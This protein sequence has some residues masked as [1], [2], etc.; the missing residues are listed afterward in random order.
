MTDQEI[1]IAIAEAMGA[2]E[3]LESP[4]FGATAY[5][6]ESMRQ[7]LEGLGLHV[8]NSDE[9]DGKVVCA[10][11]KFCNDLNAMHAAEETLSYLDLKAYRQQLMHW[12]CTPENFWRATARERAE[13]FLRTGKRRTS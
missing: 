12:P 1:N 3:I 8:N 4:G 6:P 9:R 7:S 11:P 13:A 5:W 10:V 2:D